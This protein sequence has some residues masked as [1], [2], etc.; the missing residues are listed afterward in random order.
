MSLPGIRAAFAAAFAADSIGGNL[1][2][3]HDLVFEQNAA[4]YPVFVE[5]MRDGLGGFASATRTQRWMVQLLYGFDI[6]VAGGIKALEVV[7][8]ESSVVG[9]GRFLE[10]ADFTTHASGCW[11]ERIYDQGE[12]QHGKKRYLGV[13]YDVLVYGVT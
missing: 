11:V 10:A 12:Y 7:S 4:A 8:D 3:T 5:D 13:R 2:Y 1:Y 9:L 6:D